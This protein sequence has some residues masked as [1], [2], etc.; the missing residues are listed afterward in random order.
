VWCFRFVTAAS[1]RATSSWLSTTGKVCGTRTGWTLAN[2]SPR[3]SVIS[4]KNFSPVSVALIVIGGGA[5]VDQ[6]QLKAAQIVGGRGV[7]CSFEEDGQTADCADVARLGSRLQLA[8][9]HAHVV[10]H[11]LAQRGDGRSPEFHG[12]APVEE[13]GGLPRSTTVAR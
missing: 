6:V 7:G 9:A 11:A 5:L 10:E 3:L 8:D 4:K 12:C 13:R 2:G 1:N